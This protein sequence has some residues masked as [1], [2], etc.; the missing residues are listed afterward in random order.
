MG[1]AAVYQ[2]NWIE[3][4]LTKV[5]KCKI[6]EHIYEAKKNDNDINYSDIKT[7]LI[8]FLI[9]GRVLE[10]LDF[11]IAEIEKN[12]K[13]LN[14]SIKNVDFIDEQIHEYKTYG[15]LSIWKD[16]NFRKLARYVTDIC[17]ARSQVEHNVLISQDYNELT[18]RLTTISRKYL[19]KASES[20][21]LTLNQC[22]MRDLSVGKDEAEE[23][24]RLYMQ[25]IDSMK[26]R[27]F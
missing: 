3:P 12:I 14:L 16:E 21:I 8:N 26:K 7:Q 9:Q 1:V 22:F 11:D 20:S 4:V 2:N 5:N 17:E 23:R 13:Y 6:K 19:P 25:W 18:D 27:G 10:K 24:E 15:E